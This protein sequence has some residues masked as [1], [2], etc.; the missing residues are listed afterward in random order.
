MTSAGQKY[1][2]SNGIELIET[3]FSN[4]DEFSVQKLLSGVSKDE[5]GYFRIDNEDAQEIARQVYAA[6]VS[7]VQGGDAS[8]EIGPFEEDDEVVPIMDKYFPKPGGICISGSTVSVFES[9][10]KKDRLLNLSDKDAIEAAIRIGGIYELGRFVSKKVYDKIMYNFHSSH[11]TVPTSEIEAIRFYEGFVE[12]LRVLNVKGSEGTPRITDKAVSFYNRYIRP[13]RFYAR[14]GLV[15]LEFAGKV[16]N[17]DVLM[18]GLK[19]NLF[20]FYRGEHLPSVNNDVQGI[21]AMAAAEPEATV[22]PQLAD[23]G[24]VSPIEVDQFELLCSF[25]RNVESDTTIKKI[26]DTEARKIVP[27]FNSDND[28]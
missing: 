20:G 19:D 14:G 28:Q 21:D 7:V 10:L 15:T 1:Y 6:P 5:P 22:L 8:L 12:D 27:L 2:G 16:L 11:L 24:A 23:I 25:I 13:E 3:I 26:E 4:N 9:V 18:Q 17:N